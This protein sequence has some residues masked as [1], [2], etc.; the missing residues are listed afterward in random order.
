[1]LYAIV[2]EDVADSLDLRARHRAEH[3]ARIDELQAQGRLVIA[4]PMPAID[5]EDP[6]ESGYSGSLI[7]AEFESLEAADTWAQSDPFVRGGVYARVSVKPFRQ[8]AP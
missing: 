7:V 8:S 6:G 1:M 3:R 5:S 4:G 2:A